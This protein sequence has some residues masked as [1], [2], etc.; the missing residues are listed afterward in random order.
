[1]KALRIGWILCLLLGCP[2]AFAG[3]APVSPAVTVDILQAE[4]RDT[5][6]AL[7]RQVSLPHDWADDL[8]PP[9][10]GSSQYVMKFQADASRW[11]PKDIWALYS[12]RLGDHRQILLNGVAI[13]Q[14]AIEHTKHSAERMLPQWVQFPATLL[15]DG[16]N[17]LQVGPFHD[18]LGA[19]HPVLLGPIES[20]RPAYEAA[21]MRDVRIPQMLNMATVAL[22]CFMVL[23][24]VRRPSEEII[25]A[26]GLMWL[27][28][29]LRNVSFYIPMTSVPAPWVAAW[30][31]AVGMGAALLIVLLTVAVT[32]SP[33]PRL[34]RW[35]W[36]LA[37][38]W[39]PLLALLGLAT[40]TV[41]LLR[42]VLYPTMLPLLIFAVL[43]L[44]RRL[45]GPRRG[46]ALAMF[47]ATVGVALAATHDYFFRYDYLSQSGVYWLPWVSP[48]LFLAFS[49]A[50]FNT[51]VSALD[52]SQATI[53]ELDQ[54]VRER[55]QELQ[56]AVLE[57]ARFV[58]TVSHDLRQPLHALGLL[59]G[60]IQPT[61]GAAG[62]ERMRR[63]S[64]LI[65]ALDKL[66]RGVMDVSHLDAQT[67]DSPPRP[68]PVSLAAVWQELE[69]SF[70]P[71]ARAKGL[72]LR[73]RPTTAWVVSDAHLLQRMLN[74][75]VTNAIRY[76]ER[77]AILVGARMR[78]REVIV[79]VWD[80]GIGIAA[81]RQQQIFDDFVQIGN[82]E[83]NREKGLGLGLGIVRRAAQLLQHNVQVRSRPGKGSV[84]A[85][86]LPRVVE[87]P[88]S[89]PGSGSQEP[90]PDV[91]GL[92]VL[93]VDD[94]P[95]NR[96][97]M[98]ALLSQWGC[99]VVAAGSVVEALASMHDR[100]RQ[101]DAMVVDY[102]LG[103]GTATE[104]ARRLRQ[105]QDIASP[106]LIVTGD[107][108]PA[109]RLQATQAGHDLELK[110]LGP[111][112]LLRWL[113][114]VAPVSTAGVCAG[115]NP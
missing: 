29:A 11:K 63:M 5:A 21:L 12:P 18:S 104:L 113:G 81:S 79:E 55:T 24:W 15:R 97:A 74:N 65:G 86:R 84:F 28:A 99:L 106:M 51:V 67:I 36:W 95:D 13:D 88:A 44:L 114:K 1:M 25:G 91:K 3:E 47:A 108:S 49:A 34:K 9:A 72:E 30:S 4:L 69:H 43:L 7:A 102:H 103:D 60:Q 101:P 8:R 17:L 87:L 54:R 53:R 10:A 70:G 39:C 71:L 32:D 83:R 80:T 76:T 93:I 20:V 94:E 105:E 112:T 22:A 37:L 109:V 16:E 111:D 41:D 23:V 46:Q 59:I 92:F 6:T 58:S 100:L 62:D 68:G 42:R 89:L 96:Y 98:Q 61:T 48:M 19:V 64:T 35:L 110:P 45:R 52:R 33:M 38:C 56:Q 50:L 115:A 82:P 73:L 107:A 77:G 31:F 90:L 66:L 14:H 57:K 75:F 2:N 85:L 78:E 40:G 26:L 27:P